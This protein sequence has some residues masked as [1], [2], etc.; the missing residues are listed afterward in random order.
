VRLTPSPI[1]NGQPNVDAELLSHLRAPVLITDAK[2]K[3]S[4]GRAWS[5]PSSTDADRVAF[6]SNV[7]TGESAACVFFT[8]GTT[9]APKGSIFPH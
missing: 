5:P 2:E 8:S 4:H 7:V 9:G 1:H 6:R 3:L